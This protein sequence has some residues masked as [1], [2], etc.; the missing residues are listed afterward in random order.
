MFLYNNDYNNNN[1]LIW[2]G[3][4]IVYIFV[5]MTN[6]ISWEKM[7]KIKDVHINT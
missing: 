3:W 1:K 5:C 4:K 6:Y 7:L 2:E